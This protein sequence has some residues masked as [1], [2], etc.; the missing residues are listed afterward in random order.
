MNLNFVLAIKTSYHCFVAIFALACLHASG[1]QVTLLDEEFAGG[2]GPTNTATATWSQTDGAGFE[3]YAN[4]GFAARGISGGATPAAPLGG[5]E[6]LANAAA[7]RI[8]ISISLPAELDDSVDGVFTFLG[9]QRIESGSGGFEGDLE[10]INV[11]DSRTIRAKSAVSHPNFTMAAN[12][13]AIDFVAADAGDTMEIRFYES[14]GNSARGLQLA[15]LKLDVNTVTSGEPI[16]ANPTVGSITA[17]G[18]TAD[19]E[20]SNAAA[21]VTIYHAATDYGTN[22]G[23]W[24]TNG[25]A[26]AIGN[27]AIGPVSGNLTGLMADTSY[28]MRFYAVNTDAEPDLV[29]W[30][31]PVNFST[32]LTGKAVTDLSATPWSAYEINL[33]WTDN[34]N[35][36]TSYLIQRSPAGAGTWATVATVAANTTFHTDVY[37]GLVPS[38]AYDYRVVAVNATG[39]SDPSNTASATTDPASPI[40][41][42]VLVHFDGSLDGTTYTLGEGEIDVTA[43]F[44]A[45]GSPIVAAGLATINSG[46]GGG[47]SGFDFNPFSLGNLRTRNWVAEVLISFQSFAGTLPTA[48]SVQDVDFRV[49]NAKTALE[50][51]YYNL[52]TDVRE[53]TA[54]PALG[55]RVHLALVWDASTGTLYGYVNG[56]AIGPVSGGAYAAPDPTNVSFGYF[57]RLG[58]DNRGVDG[59]LDAVSFRS[60]TGSFNP[61]SD[62]AIL[63]IGS[64]FSGWIDDFGLAPA[65]FGFT[66][67]PDNDGIP[68]GVEAFFGTNPNSP[69]TGI[70]NVTTNGTVTTFTHPQADPQLDD[71]NTTYQWSSD[72]AN[73]YDGDGVDGPGGGLTVEIPGVTPVAGISTVTATA[74]QPVPSLFLRVRAD[75]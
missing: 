19:S 31:A 42:D 67:D 16:L 26:T 12:S 63:P 41:T 44:K 29:A 9:G 60:G 65:E 56:A 5:L 27:Q 45:N 11:T 2:V 75:L 17:T 24:Q 35:T 13:V 51:V 62:F 43:T 68:N 46:A 40:E 36:E 8:T 28:V 1:A 53:T 20:L 21:T 54:L 47:T 38:T 4:G 25:T 52:S 15:D 6:V 59:I 64:S 3:V 33:S 73:W 48:L 72:L 70:A 10:I 57:G 18:A 66:L 71:V 32:A 69:S 50:A 30:S 58:F 61:S 74:S 14:A 37:T 49:N 23:D 7:N 39:N 34:F 55:T 22:V